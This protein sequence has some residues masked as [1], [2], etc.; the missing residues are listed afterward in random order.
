M[1]TI[2]WACPHCK[3]V[4]LVEAKAG[5]LVCPH[6]QEDCGR[7]DDEYFPK[8]CPRCSCSQFYLVKDFNQGYGCLIM[9]IGILLVPR[10]YGLSLPAVWLLDLFLFKRVPAVVNCYLCG[11]EFRGF[12]IPEHI[13]PFIHQIGVKYDRKRN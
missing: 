9:L 6:C 2:S 10:T 5:A 4:A 13:K 7:V 8:E 3:K 12:E 11:A 1:K